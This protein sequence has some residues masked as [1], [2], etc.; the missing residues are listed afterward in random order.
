V[1]A[2]GRRKKTNKRQARSY[3]TP[4]PSTMQSRSSHREISKDGKRWDGATVGF[5]ILLMM[6]LVLLIMGIFSLM[7][8]VRNDSNSKGHTTLVLPNRTVF[9]PGQGLIPSVINGEYS[10]VSL[11]QT[12][13]LLNALNHPS[14]CVLGNADLA[15]LVGN[16]VDT[17]VVVLTL[18]MIE[19]SSSSQITGISPSLAVDMYGL[20]PNAEVAVATLHS[21]NRYFLMLGTAKLGGGGLAVMC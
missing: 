14:S 13:S 18:A 9:G 21:D 3:I 1:P 17:G 20:D 10:W 6:A 8:S 2:I 7:S 12:R 5:I 15:V 11:P 16:D 19:V 4:S